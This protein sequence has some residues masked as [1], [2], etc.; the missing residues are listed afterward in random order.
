MKLEFR[1]LVRS[2]DFCLVINRFLTFLIDELL[3]TFEYQQRFPEKLFAEPS[4]MGENE[5]ISYIKDLKN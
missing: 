4:G 3:H 5:T 1:F 2:L